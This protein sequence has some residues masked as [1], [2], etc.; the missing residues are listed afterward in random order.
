MGNLYEQTQQCDVLRHGLG[1]ILA[2]CQ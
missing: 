1:G 2:T